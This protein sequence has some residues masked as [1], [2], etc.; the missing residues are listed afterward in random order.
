[1]QGRSL[2]DHT[3]QGVT[4]SPLATAIITSMLYSNF[5]HV[6]QTRLVMLIMFLGGFLSIATLFLSFNFECF[7]HFF[8]YLKYDNVNVVVVMYDY[9]Y[10]MSIDTTKIIYHYDNFFTQSRTIIMAW[11]N[12]DKYDKII[13]E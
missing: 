1:M 7:Q 12:R 8:A 11:N 3:F 2:E 9:G 13:S 4:S 6:I 5:T 10:T